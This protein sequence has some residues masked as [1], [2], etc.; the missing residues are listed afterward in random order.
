ML[1]IYLL[2]DRVHMVSGKNCSIVGRQSKTDDWEFVVRDEAQKSLK[3][4]FHGKEG[5]L[6]LSFHDP[7]LEEPPKQFGLSE[8]AKK[9]AATI[10][11]DL[12][13]EET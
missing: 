13:E 9:L 2:G 11:K 6:Y 7:S 1:K 4:T 3:L 8:E 12:D 10:S 5:K